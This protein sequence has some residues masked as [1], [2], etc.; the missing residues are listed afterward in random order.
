MTEAQSGAF[1]Y[2]GLPAD[3][4]TIMDRYGFVENSNFH[5]FCEDME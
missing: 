4:K 3:A 2:R 1:I 5:K